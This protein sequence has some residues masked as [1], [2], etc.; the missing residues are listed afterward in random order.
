MAAPLPA[1][2]APH[3][4]EGRAWWAVFVLFLAYTLSYIDRMIISLMVEPLRADLDLSD[5]QISLLQG[6]AF[7][8]FYTSMAIP[9]AA[10]AD[11]RSRT[12]IV[13]VGIAFWSAMTAACGLAGNFWQLFLARMGVGVGE[14]TLSPATYSLIADLFPEDKRGRAMAI[15]SSGVSVGGGLAFIIGGIIIGFA[16]TS[17]G[18]ET[19][20]GPVRAWQ[21][22]FLILGPPGLLL[23]LLA[24][25]IPEPR[26]R[27]AATAATPMP[28]RPFLVREWR[29][30][31]LLFVGNGISG[32][33][34]T[35][36]LSWAPTFLIRAYGETPAGAGRMLGIG[37]LVLGPIGAIAGGAISDRWTRSGAATASLSVV[38]AGIALMALFGAIAPF[39][40]SAIGASAMFSLA[41]LFGAAAY[42]PGAVAVQKLAPAPLRAR[43]AALYLFV[44]TLLSLA[45]APTA[46]ALLTDRIFGDPALIG[47]SLTSFTAI[48]GPIGVICIAAAMR[49]FRASLVRQEP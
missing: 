11:R 7:A 9:I 12:A 42:P 44:V 20:F 30:L 1:S 10:L 33:I 34:T 35:A 46:V 49:A 47:R 39:M 29:T 15:F 45:L 28:L 41:L 3:I 40:P 6:L 22:V 23:A 19:P 24:L 16:T 25:T 37:L 26:R 14:A 18:H 48:A 17:G 31:T 27:I 43:I 32:M 8:I 36:L 5:T 2:D 4:G 38:G 13:A 21:L